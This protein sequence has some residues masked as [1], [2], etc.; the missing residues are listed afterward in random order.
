M[1]T[2]RQNAQSGNRH[3]E[4]VSDGFEGYYR[5]ALSTV[6][7]YHRYAFDEYAEF[8]QAAALAALEALD[9]LG[10]DAPFLKVAKAVQ[11]HLRLQAKAYGWMTINY[12][13]PDGTKSA[14]TGRR[15]TT[16][17][18]A[19]EESESVSEPWV[20]RRSRPEYVGI[21]PW[22]K[23]AIKPI[24]ELLFGKDDGSDEYIED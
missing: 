20:K 3:D 16:M 14:Y 23:L 9:E 24:D 7:R 22:G 11:K 4:N 12:R 19:D 17:A 5:V 18:D 8:S 10:P 21:S 15:V 2:L 6:W 13:K 1:A